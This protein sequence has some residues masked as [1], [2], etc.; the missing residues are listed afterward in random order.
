MGAKRPLRLVYREPQACFIFRLCCLFCL[1]GI[2]FKL[3]CIAIK[4]MFSQIKFSL[5][6]LGELPEPDLSGFNPVYRFV[7][8]HFNIGLFVRFAP[9][10]I[11]K[12]SLYL[13]LWNSAFFKL[14]QIFP[15]FSVIVLKK[16]FSLDFHM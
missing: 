11:I 14:S 15:D 3:S 4:I 5:F 10:S 9:F 7:L 2:I 1:L 13:L 8:L 12:C 16:F 6:R